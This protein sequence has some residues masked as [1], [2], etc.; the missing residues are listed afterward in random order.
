MHKRNTCLNLVA[1]SLLA[2]ALVFASGC[3]S[4]PTRA[5]T[6]LTE[7]RNPNAGVNRR[8]AAVDSAWA[9]AP[10]GAPGHGGTREAMKSLAWSEQTPAPLRLKI[11]QKLLED[12]SEEGRRDTREMAR[13][14]IPSVRS[15]AV[16]ALLADAAGERGWEE[17]IPAL[18]RS[19]AR[20]VESIPDAQRAERRALEKLARGKPVEEIAFEMFL[21]PPEQEKLQNVDLTERLR[22]SAWDL[23]AR[24]DSSGDRRLALLDALTNPSSV[25]ANDP[26]LADIQASARDLRAIPL[27]G[28]EIRWL[29]SKR[30]D[31]AQ[32]GTLA[33]ESTLDA[34]AA[35]D[36]QRWR[37]ARDAIAALPRDRTGPL[38]LRHVEVVRWASR[39]R[40]EWTGATRD[41]LLAKVRERLEDRPVN[42]R[43]AGQGT[44]SG[45][46]EETL[47]DWEAS[48][49]W[50]DLLTLLCVLDAMEDPDVQAAVFRHAELDRKDTTTEYGGVLAA[51]DPPRESG[52]G[53]PVQ[54]PGVFRITL[55]PPRPGQ[56]L[57]DRQFVASDDMLAASDWA[58]AHYHL[59]VQKPRNNAY[60]G[61]SDG[62]LDYAQRSRR[63]CLVFTSLNDETL[64]VDYYQAGDVVIDLGEIER[65][66]N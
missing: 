4:G 41:E 38:S 62:D 60:A 50:G 10:P 24:L 15:A 61:P 1:V 16:V 6:P 56:R 66:G 17:C 8:V 65:P 29:R 18:V 64:G 43:S 52:S 51:S 54:G 7:M 42:P 21:N 14:M 47:R 36:R 58:I 49:R 5:A 39:A 55:Y 27:T 34:R 13:L 28:E 25:P 40:P 33:D 30:G 22:L 53:G 11:V 44:F 59:H 46:A 31:L 3:S 19:Y 32:G 45:R 63:A 57:G 9:A 12:E 26:L 20:V 37:E 23:L 35:A 2:G 48:L